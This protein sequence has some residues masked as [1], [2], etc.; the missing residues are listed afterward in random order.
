MHLKGGRRTARGPGFPAE[1][2]REAHDLLVGPLR[3]VGVERV[4]RIDLPGTF[5]EIPPPVTTG[6]TS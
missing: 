1:P 4:E 6:R 3:D 5:G 2:V